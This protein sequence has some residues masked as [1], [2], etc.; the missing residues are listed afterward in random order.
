MKK[1]SRSAGFYVVLALLVL[2][3]ASKVLAPGSDSQK[4][5]LS[6]FETKI[7]AGQVHNVPVEVQLHPILRAPSHHDDVAILGY[8]DAER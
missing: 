6:E 5:K 2:V 7:A 1:L 3:A 8:S 4:L